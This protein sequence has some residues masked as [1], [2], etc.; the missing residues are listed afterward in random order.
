MLVD[1]RARPK[2][3]PARGW[4]GA[5]GRRPRAGGARAPSRS[6]S[7]IVVRGRAPARR[8]QAGGPRRP[9]CRRPPERDAGARAARARRRR[10]RPRAARHRPPARPRHLRACSSSPARRRRTRGCREADPRATVDRRYLALVRGSAALAHRANHARRSAGTA[11]TARGTRSTPTRRARRSRGSR[12]ASAIGE[13][14]LLDVRLETGRTHQIRVHLE[15]ARAS[16]VRRPR[17]RRRAATSGSSGS[18]STPTGSR[19]SIRSPARQRRRSSRRC[20]GTDRVARRPRAGTKRRLTATIPQFET[21]NP[22]TPPDG[23]ARRSQPGSVCARR[24]TDTTTERTNRGSRLHEGAAGGRGA[25]R[26]PDA[27][28]EPE[29]EALH[30]RRARRH[31]HHRPPA[32]AGAAAGGARFRAEHRRARGHHPLRRH[33]EA[34]AGRDRP[35]GDAR[36]AAV[37]RATAGSAAC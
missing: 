31:L 22:A 27:P 25:L 15:A 3:Y 33:E 1:G 24:R 13:R 5:R 2:S 7:T 10:R 17:L 12:C 14:T 19:S 37:R 4:G 35:R 18:S 6:R 23:G 16:G 28:L 36:R 9:S 32:D 30:L 34:G 11:A 20:R 8:R 29:D 21:T 26:P